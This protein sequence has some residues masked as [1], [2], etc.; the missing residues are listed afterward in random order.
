M[1][2]NASMSYN[3]RLE[4]TMRK[5]LIL[6]IIFLFLLS[7]CG[8]PANSDHGSSNTTS[9]S[10]PYT[11]GNANV[12]DNFIESRN[13]DLWVRI[14]TP[15]HNSTVN[16]QTLDV[17]G[18]APAG[19]VITIDDQIILVPPD[20]FFRATVPLSLEANFIEIIASDV[21]GTEIK[22]KLLVTYQP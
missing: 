8:Q 17:T 14:L 12:T 18:Q 1:L 15:K 6:T 5:V 21:N 19:T 13:G 7:A 11:S 2:N 20:Q 10:E 3:R 9:G 22:I 16:T 4:S